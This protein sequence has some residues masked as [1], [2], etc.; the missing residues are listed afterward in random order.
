MSDGLPQRFPQVSQPSSSMQLPSPRRLFDFSR[1]I[2]PN[3]GSTG[4]GT[5]PQRPVPD[6]ICETCRQAVPSEVAVTCCGCNQ[7]AHARCHETLI[8]GERFHMQMCMCCTNFVKH[9]LRISRA[10]EERSFLVWRE[11]EWFRIILDA[12]L[13]G[14]TVPETTNQSLIVLQNYM[15]RSLQNNLYVWE[16]HP[17]VSETLEAARRE[18]PSLRS[19]TVDADP[20]P[21]GQLLPVPLMTLPPG[22]YRHL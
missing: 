19:P 11:D 5:S 3:Q 8:I 16:T 13:T 10:Y 6:A 22:F 21:I 9:L 18:R 12:H 1:R 17:R 20:S 4:D 2:A 7:H 15:L 14:S